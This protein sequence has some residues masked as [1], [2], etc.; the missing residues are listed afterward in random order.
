MHKTLWLALGLSALALFAGCDDDSGSTAD[1]ATIHGTLTL[2]GAWPA[3]GEIQISLFPQWDTT[4]PMAVAPGGPPEFSTDH[5]SSPT[6]DDTLHAIAYTLDDVNPGDYPA[7]VV[8]WRNGGTLGVDEP[9]IGMHGGDFGAGDTLPEAL[10][11]GAGADLT[12]DFDGWLDL[13]PGSVAISDT[14]WVRGTVVFPGDWPTGYALGLYALMMSSGDPAQPTS[15]IPGAMQSVSAASPDFELPVDLTGG[16]F[17]GHFAVYGYPFVDG[18]WASFYGGYGWDWNAAE[19]A[20]AP[21]EL[22]PE[23]AVLENL[24]ILCRSQN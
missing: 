9:V 13:V 22:T 10:Q 24:T 14:G 11:V 21:V 8:G 15:P 7:L 3:D 19:P 2:H 23:N 12:I 4:I 16:P 6:P 20:L 5:L 1:L 17:S 18:A